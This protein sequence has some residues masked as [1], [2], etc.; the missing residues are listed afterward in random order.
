MH[1]PPSLPILVY[2][3]NESALLFA[4]EAR[5]TQENRHIDLKY[6]IMSNLYH[7]GFVDYQYIPSAENLADIGTKSMLADSTYELLR[8][9]LVT[10]REPTGPNQPESQTSALT[11]T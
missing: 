9:R 2:G 5:V 7:S 3:D 8:D 4:R 10:P 1:F 11:G 6:C